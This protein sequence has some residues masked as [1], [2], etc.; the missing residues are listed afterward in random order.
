MNCRKG[1]TKNV[2]THNHHRLT[3]RLR[4]KKLGVTCKT[5]SRL[6][7]TLLAYRC[8]D[9]CR[10]RAVIKLLCSLLKC[11]HSS[12]CRL[13]SSLSG[14]NLELLIAHLNKV[15]SAITSLI[16]TRAV[17]ETQWLLILLKLHKRHIVLS[18]L[19]ITIDHRRTELCNHRIGK[20]L[21]NYLPANTVCVTLC[22]SYLYSIIEH[23]LTF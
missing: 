2:G 13:Y 18:R 8:G 11:R 19:A 7:H 15:H 22:Y 16:C 17:E 23:C 3:L 20:S 14:L 6:V 1:Y 10:N 21:E 4:G 5:K 12:L 9:N